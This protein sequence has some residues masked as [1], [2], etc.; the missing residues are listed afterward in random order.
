MAKT[1]EPVT[2]MAP[3]PTADPV[4]VEESKWERVEAIFDAWADGQEPKFEE[5]NWLATVLTRTEF[6]RE[7][8][9]GQSRRKWRLQ[10]G[11]RAE[12]ADAQKELEAAKA[13]EQEVVA[14][15]QA[16]VIAAT[17]KIAAARLRTTT[18]TRRVDDQTAA[19]TCLRELRLLGPR[20]EAQ[21]HRRLAIIREHPK[22]KELL[23]AR[24]RLLA[25]D[26]VLEW[27]LESH[28][29]QIAQYVNL[30]ANDEP[31]LD[32]VRYRTTRPRVPV[33]TGVL[34]DEAIRWWEAHRVQ[35]AAEQTELRGFVREW[36]DHF[37]EAFEAVE[38]LREF[39]VDKAG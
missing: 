17:S 38:K 10:M 14:A 4:A 29:P 3:D 24:S 13:S 36:G 37:H 21:Y 19:V 5:L 34:G 25:V 39:L 9:L 28:R 12:R 1:K 35:L 7:R 16:I 30:H 22:Y 26:R 32:L 11:T 27:T 18:A 2:V 20:R 23:Q 31:T 15:Q 6:Q 33:V 8:E